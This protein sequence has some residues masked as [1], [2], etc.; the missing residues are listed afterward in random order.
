MESKVTFKIQIN[1]IKQKLTFHVGIIYYH[2]IE[3]QVCQLSE[4]IQPQSRNL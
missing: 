1:Q 3:I 4:S 2:E